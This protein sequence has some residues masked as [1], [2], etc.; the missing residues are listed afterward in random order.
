MTGDPG[1]TN[2]LRNDEVVTK[3]D[4]VGGRHSDQGVR[5]G[6]CYCRWMPRASSLLKLGFHNQGTDALS[7]GRSDFCKFETE[8]GTLYPP[9]Q[10]FVDA[11]GPFLI[12]QE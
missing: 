8:S 10:G 12:L 4:G 5:E 3:N 9:N 2:S 6:G 1:F 7:L 11:Y